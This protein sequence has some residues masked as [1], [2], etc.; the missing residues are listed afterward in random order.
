VVIWGAGPVGKSWSRALRA[1][2]HTV[3][4]FVEV[5]PRKIGMRIHDA[6]V[7]AVAAV[8]GLPPAL[9][10]AAVGSRAGREAIRAAGARAGLRDGREMVAVA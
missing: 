6:P 1:R 9:H 4:A 10:L 2:G 8:G 5:D 7:L 3:C